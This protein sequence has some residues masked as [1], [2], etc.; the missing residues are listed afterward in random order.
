MPLRWPGETARPPAA[1]QRTCRADHRNAGCPKACRPSCAI[2]PDDP[3]G[4]KLW[5]GRHES[6]CLPGADHTRRLP[7]P[8]IRG[9]EAGRLDIGAATATGRLKV[10]TGI[11]LIPQRGPIVTAK[12]VSTISQLSQVRFLFGV[13]NGWHRRPGATRRACRS[14]SSGR[15]IRSIIRTPGRRLESIPDLSIP[16]R[17]MGGAAADHRPLARVEAV[18]GGVRRS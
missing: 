13:G 17:R 8:P 3:A 7:P 1:P 4:G 16:G 15:R 12:R 18:A 11:A 2:R 9:R 14:A 5:A 10:G 6:Q